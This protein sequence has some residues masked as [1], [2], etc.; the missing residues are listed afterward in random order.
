MA[1]LCSKETMKWLGVASVLPRTAKCV[2]PQIPSLPGGGLPAGL[3][4]VFPLLEACRSAPARKTPSRRLCATRTS[5]RS[6]GPAWTLTAC[7][8]PV[9][10]APETGL[11]EIGVNDPDKRF[12]R[13]ANDPL[14]TTLRILP[15]VLRDLPS[16][17]GSLRET[18]ALDLDDNAFCHRLQPRLKRRGSP[19]P[20][21]YAALTLPAVRHRVWPR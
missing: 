17:Q 5:T 3:R 10:I 15:P 13:A 1:R 18:A 14:S 2:R 12:P 11:I 9:D 8:G 7:N 21:G 20:R 16:F 19:L 6:S 4:N